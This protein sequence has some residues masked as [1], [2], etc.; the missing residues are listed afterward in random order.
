MTVTVP[1]L[2]EELELITG[3]DDMPLIY[4]PATG[5]YHRVSRSG[6]AILQR[7]DG[8]HT[9]DDLAGLAQAAD[10]DARAAFRKQLD[11]FLA[12]LER[13][14][15]LVGSELPDVGERE[16]RVRTS[17]LMPR[18]V[19]TRELPRILE[20]VA[21]LL[22]GAPLGV[23]GPAAVVLAV[24]G[25]GAGVTTLVARGGMWATFDPAPLLT[26][27]ALQLTLILAHE[28]SHAL[29]AQVLGVPVR[30]LGFAVLFWFMPVAY[31][32]RTDAYRLR[33]RRGRV[34]IAV[35]GMT[36]DGILCG[37]VAALAW[38]ASGFWSDT[39]LLL[40]TF[41]IIGLVIN[42]N[43]LLPSDGFSALEAATGLVNFRARAFLYLR[44]T[45]TRTDLPSHLRR[46]SWRRRAGFVAYAVVALV[47]VLAA[48][49]MFV[50]LFVG[51]TGHF[52]EVFG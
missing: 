37:V 44:S 33:G 7:L 47:Y 28:S 21:A 13:S 5:V 41:Q 42:T 30:G 6:H 14:G 49:F 50:R 39:L 27:I 51:M 10:D 52:M 11:E 8:S 22:R 40:L 45:V 4:D 16:G 34:A 17:R 26:A 31:V 19:I 36:T 9:A 32:D 18:V 15:L 24:V 20:P 46:L 38:N 35:A 23:L 1:Q 3:M 12:H 2:R 25:F 48:A 29:V 43:P